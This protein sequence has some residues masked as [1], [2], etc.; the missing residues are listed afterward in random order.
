[1]TITYFFRCYK[2]T[3][4]WDTQITFWSLI[5]CFLT[6]LKVLRDWNLI[7]HFYFLHSVYTRINARQYNTERR[8]QIRE[9]E[10]KTHWKVELTASGLLNRIW[11][12]LHGSQEHFNKRN[13]PCEQRVELQSYFISFPYLIQL[14][15][16]IIKKQRN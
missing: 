4:L 2:N 14:H 11:L 16:H 3:A 13:L 10:E 8:Q 1:M 9:K 12:M 7:Y 6:I 15:I 5:F